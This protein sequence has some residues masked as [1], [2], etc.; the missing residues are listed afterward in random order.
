ML[1]S[2]E[3]GPSIDAN[4]V[5]LRQENAKLLKLWK[6]AEGYGWRLINGRP[7]VP[8]GANVPHPNM[9]IFTVAPPRLDDPRVNW[10]G[11]WTNIAVVDEVT[12]KRKYYISFPHWFEQEV[13]KD[14]PI[15]VSIGR[16][17]PNVT[18]AVE[19]WS[20][21]MWDLAWSK[22]SSPSDGA[23]PPPY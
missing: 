13:A 8:I 5:A 6:E 20:D 18:A 23:E 17:L 21:W 10:A 3:T 22:F 14:R 1:R 12:K 2:P 9:R 19:E 7:F 4:L 11:I 16:T 15:A